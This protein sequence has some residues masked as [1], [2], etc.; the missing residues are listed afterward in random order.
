MVRLTRTDVNRLLT[1]PVA[2]LSTAATLG[3][4]GRRHGNLW[5]MDSRARSLVTGAGGFVGTHLVR[6]LLEVGGRVRAMVRDGARLPDG[7]ERVTADLTRPE[8]LGPALD[9]VE[10]VYHTAAITANLKEPYRGAYDRVNRQGTEDLVAAAARAGAGR[11]V[12]LSGLGTRAAAAG[13]YMA[14]RWGMEEAVRRSGLP[15]VILRP[16]VLFGDGAEFVAALARLVRQSPVVPVLGPPDLRFQPLW[17]D[18]LVSC[19]VKSGGSEVAAGSAISLG[20]AEY[21]TMRQIIEAIAQSLGERRRLV[22]VPLG[23]AGVQAGLMS[24]LLP[25]PPL[26]PAALELFGFDNATRIDSVEL[27]FGFRPRGFTEH[28]LAR[29]VD[30]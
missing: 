26:T 18:D 24:A 29:G 21:V 16:S 17:I 8:T 10:V 5:D 12:V 20:G 11:L 2:E 27:A 19:L 22:P 30:G 14:T 25:R 28:L 9:G 6:R 1:P 15:Y 3:T 4:G 13:T 23:L 7:V